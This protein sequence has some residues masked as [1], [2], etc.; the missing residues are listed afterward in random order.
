MPVS[1]KAVFTPE[2]TLREKKRRSKSKS[3]KA[4]RKLSVKND[5]VPIKKKHSNKKVQDI[6]MT[7]IPK[8][9]EDW[10]IS[11]LFP[12]VKKYALTQ[13]Q[14][15]F[16]YSVLQTTLRNLKEFGIVNRLSHFNEHKVMI[17]AFV[18]Q[19]FGTTYEAIELVFDTIMDYHEVKDAKMVQEQQASLDDLLG[20]LINSMNA[21]K[22]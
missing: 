17:A 6:V 10:K 5:A 1:K 12:L 2:V 13:E 9:Y 18:S 20:S 16:Y 7:I 8:T 3:Q 22:I 14:R 15:S 19:Q 21:I 4:N 11:D